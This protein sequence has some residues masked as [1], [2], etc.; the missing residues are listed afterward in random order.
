MALTRIIPGLILSLLGYPCPPST[1]PHPHDSGLLSIHCWLPWGIV[2]LVFEHS[3]FQVPSAAVSEGS[4]KGPLS[5]W[6]RLSQWS[7]S[8]RKM[9]RFVSFGPVN[10]CCGQ[11]YAKNEIA[12]TPTP[13]NMYATC[14][15]SFFSSW[16]SPPFLPRQCQVCHSPETCIDTIRP[17]VKK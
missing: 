16:S 2:N 3:A 9:L 14:V 11:L 13:K 4:L 7:G 1:L 12:P 6:R 17:K 15:T 8:S 10:R 5:T